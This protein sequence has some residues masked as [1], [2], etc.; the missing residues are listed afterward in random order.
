MPASESTSFLAS[1][2]AGIVNGLVQGVNGKASMDCDAAGAC[3]IKLTGLPIAQLD[4]TCQAG[5]C[6]V[7]TDQTLNTTT[8]ESRGVGCPVCTRQAANA[9]VPVQWRA[10][11]VAVPCKAWHARD[12]WACSHCWRP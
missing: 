4:A 3:S 9:L 7:P 5:E 10:R 11:F 12:L 2:P 8:G 6:L 1:R